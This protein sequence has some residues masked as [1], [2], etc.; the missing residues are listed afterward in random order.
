MTSK[1][2]DEPEIKWSLWSGQVVGNRIN[3]IYLG[4]GVRGYQI[5][6]QVLRVP[7]RWGIFSP[8]PPRL[9]ANEGFSFICAGTPVALEALFAIILF[10]ILFSVGRISPLII[11]VGLSPLMS[12]ATMVYFLLKTSPQ[13]APGYVFDD[14]KARL[15]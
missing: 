10:S 7:D 12:V 4:I 3:P 1:A 6:S 13:R 14:W 8:G 11:A 2:T 5:Q 9:Q 15:E